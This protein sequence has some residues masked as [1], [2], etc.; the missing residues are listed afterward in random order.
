MKKSLEIVW[1]YFEGFHPQT[2][3]QTEVINR[4]LGDMLRC[5]VGVKRGVWDFILSIAEF[6]YN[7]YVNRSTSKI[8]FQIVNGYSPRTLIDL[9][10]LPS[11]MHV[12]EPAENFAKHI[13]DLH[14]KIR[15]KISL[16]NEE[17]KLVVDVHRRSKEFNVGEYVMVRIRL[18]RIPKMFSKKLYARTIGPFSIIRKLGSNAYLL[19]L[20]ND[21]DISHVFNVED[22]LPYRGTFEPSSVST[23]EARKGAPNVSSL[24]FSKEMVDIIILDN[25][26]VTSRDGGF[27][28]FLVK[29]NGRPDSDATWIQEDDL[30]H[31]DHSLWDCYISSYF[32]ESSSFQLGEMMGHGVGPYLSLDEIGSPSPMMI[33]IIIIIY[34]ILLFGFVY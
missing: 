27:R 9:V 22:L 3:S 20:P 21:M 16:S 11:H 18:E 19:D 33:F 5:L 28:R 12:S 14:A 26:F 23:G 2:D 34:L 13:H 4:S 24:Q 7:N 8:H 17:Y 15:R 10:P 30:H 25:E 29:W 6:A 32:S 31:L 1:H